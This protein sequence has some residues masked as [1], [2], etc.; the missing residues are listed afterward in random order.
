MEI[1]YEYTSKNDVNITQIVAYMDGKLLIEEYS[2]GF[3]K[4]IP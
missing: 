1:L 3:T 4:S 2:Y